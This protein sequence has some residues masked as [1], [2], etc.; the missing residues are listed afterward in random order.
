MKLDGANSQPAVSGVDKLEGIV[1][2]FIGNNP[3]K[4]QT[5]IPTFGRVQ[6]AGVYEG[7]DMGYYGNQQQ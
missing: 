2:Y 7:V 4:W 1:N 5:N 6:Y 3:D